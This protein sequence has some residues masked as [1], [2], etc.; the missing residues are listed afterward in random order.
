MSKQSSL[1]LRQADWK[2][3]IKDTTLPGWVVTGICQLAHSHGHGFGEM[4][5]LNLNLDYI[6][7]FEQLQPKG[8]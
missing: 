7:V 4:E 2:Q 5:V 3:A 6:H 8:G 1:A